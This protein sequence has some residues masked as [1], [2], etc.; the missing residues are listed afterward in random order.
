LEYLIDQTT[1][2][3]LAVPI[4]KSGKINACDFSPHASFPQ[5]LYACL[6][7]KKPKGVS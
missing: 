5:I 4:K 6:N 2:G 7:R 3:A 1:S